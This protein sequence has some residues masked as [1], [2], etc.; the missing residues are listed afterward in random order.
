MPAFFKL[1]QGAAA[2]AG[3]RDFLAKIFH[4]F[5]GLDG[6]SD[7][8]GSKEIEKVEKAIA[9]LKGDT[10]E[11]QQKIKGILDTAGGKSEDIDF[12]MRS[13]MIALWIA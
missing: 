6:K 3:V 1:I 8:F 12:L 2:A 10:A 4:E 11:D 9:R 13:N 5:K 7:L